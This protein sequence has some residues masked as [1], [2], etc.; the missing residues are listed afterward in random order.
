MLPRL[1]FAIGRSAAAGCLALMLLT[2]PGIAGEASSSVWSRNTYPGPGHAERPERFVPGEGSD[3]AEWISG[4]GVSPLIAQGHDT[5][6]MLQVTD[7]GPLVV[8][9]DGK[10][11]V[12]ADLPI[13]GGHAVA[14]SPHDGNRAYA[15]MRH[16][17]EID[18]DHA[19]WRSDD[20]G[21]TWRHMVDA[22]EIRGQQ[23]NLIHDPHPDRADH[24]YLAAADAGLKVSTDDGASWS[25][26]ALSGR[27]VHTL[28]AV[29]DGDDTL[30]YAVVSPN[31]KP[32][33]AGNLGELLRWRIDSAGPSQATQQA[34]LRDDV[35]DV[36]THAEHPDRLWLFTKADNGE[37]AVLVADADAIGEAELLHRGFMRRGGTIRVNPANANHLI[38]T[39][40]GPIVRQ[41]YD[42]SLDGGR[43]WQSY[44]VRSIDGEDVVP[45]FTDYGPFNHDSPHDA[46]SAAAHNKIDGER[47]LYGFW[48]GDPKRVLAWFTNMPK[49][50]LQSDDGGLTF[51]PFASGGT[52][53]P[54]DQIA[55]SQD[56]RTRVQ[57]MSEYGLLIT[58]DAGQTWRAHHHINQPVLASLY[59][60]HQDHPNPWRY[61]TAWGVAVDPHDA[62][63]IVA[64]YGWDP[65][66]VVRT[67]DGGAT[68]QTLH[69][70]R[71][72]LASDL[73][74]PYLDATGVF[75]HRQDPDV[76][77]V[78][79]LR[80]TDGGRTFHDLPGKPFVTSMS[81]HHG[82]LVACREF[83][84]NLWLS[85]DRGESWTKLPGPPR[86]DGFSVLA[87]Y[88]LGAIAFDTRPQHDP[89]AGGGW[90]ILIGGT[91]GVWQ[92]LAPPQQPDQGQWSLIQPRTDHDGLAEALPAMRFG[93]VVQDPD[94]QRSHRYIAS[95]G[96]YTTADRRLYR[97][98]ALI[99]EDHGQTWRDLDHAGLTELTP[100]WKPTAAPAIC[101]QT[102]EVFFADYTGLYAAR[103]GPP[104]R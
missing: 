88:S 86:A 40:F 80:S 13:A 33:N 72:T 7:L 45:A 2:L 76:V 97:G 96:G 61:K 6:L 30:L 57:A 71:P 1:P 62:Q 12:P 50:P 24:L 46:V 39:A 73:A 3:R 66:H 70:Y 9:F 37:G 4:F 78:G 38:R 5:P 34:N 100:W 79:P 18:T 68:W 101:P 36:E 90:R 75:W 31:A 67:E 69:Q 49:A 41:P 53:K 87:N 85:H 103:P 22:P 58:A 42:L 8:S 35:I 91:G 82:D 27:F 104:P 99:S 21:R 25:T 32:V 29:A 28:A 20:R 65:V 92:Y 17:P 95:V 44:E 26:L 93:Y 84:S 55:V 15:F 52:F 19:W 56:G 14:F 59:A 98:G 74:K 54:A 63:T 64:T 48:P 16:D 47:P 51:E 94:P 102:G 89:T 11:F 81:P 83:G 23:R 60:A 10:R 43:T 77:Y